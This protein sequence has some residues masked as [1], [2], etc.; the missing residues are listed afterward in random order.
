MTWRIVLTP[1]AR[2]Q[3]LAV[4]D[5]RERDL[6][7]GR[8]DTLAAEPER[9]GKSMH[10]ALAGYY[11]VRAAGQRYRILYTLDRET[12]IVHV[13]ALGI[14]REGDKRDVYALAQRLFRVG[15]LAPEPG[16]DEPAT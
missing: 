3:L 16:D 14:R 12:I 5:R 8:I 7:A 2:A 9:Q 10:G 15:L 4:R 6:I 1:T 13:V 11:S